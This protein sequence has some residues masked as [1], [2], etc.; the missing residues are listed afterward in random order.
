MLQCPLQQLGHGGVGACPCPC[1][2]PCHHPCLNRVSCLH[3]C[4]PQLAAAQPR[5]LQL[6]LL[7]LLCLLVQASLL[8]HGCCPLQQQQGACHL[9]PRLGSHLSQHVLACQI[10]G[11]QLLLGQ[12]AAACL[13]HCSG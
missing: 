8:L 7:Q 3:L 13:H 9:H 6:P 11:H 4:L 12:A 5:S 10:G 2:C 1:P